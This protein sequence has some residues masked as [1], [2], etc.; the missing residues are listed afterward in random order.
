MSSQ[1]RLVQT[2]VK[3]TPRLHQLFQDFRLT[4][5]DKAVPW[6]V[7]EAITLDPDAQFE[8]YAQ[9]RVG[10]I[11]PLGLG[12]FTYSHSG[13]YTEMVVG[14]YCSI[15]FGVAVIPADHPMDWATSSPI[16]HA[17]RHITGL[18]LYLADRG[19]RGFKLH[20][21]V[22]DRKPVVIGNDVWIGT[23]VLIKRGVTIGHGAVI[24]AGSIVTKDIPPY[25]I[26]VGTPARII[27]YRFPEPLIDRML[28]SEW[29]R[30]GPEKL[31]PL[32]MREPEAFLDRL[33][34]EVAR[35]LSPLNLPML[36]GRQIMEAGVPA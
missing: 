4:G 18:P 11:L 22:L 1:P 31:Q 6:K 28:A 10:L 8:R 30:Y 5:A 32:D 25:A 20:P 33:E 15:A 12:A 23:H 16:T 9:V 17:P 35:G 3:I 13:F 26:A 14:R 29:W 7:G 19:E 36:T 2:N 24:G 34:D 21:M 27:R